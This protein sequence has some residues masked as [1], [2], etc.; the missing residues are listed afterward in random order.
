M[1]QISRAALAEL[2]GT[3]A[4]IFFGAGAILSDAFIV[5]VENFP[6]GPG[7]LAI[8]LAHGLTITVMVCA[9]GHISGG[10][11][12]PAVTLSMTLTK[13]L[14]VTH[15]LFYIVAQLLGAALAAFFL[16]AI[17]PHEALPV[18]LGTPQLATTL[19]LAQGFFTE[20]LLTFF[21]VFVIFGTAVDARGPRLL[22]GLAI[23]LTLTLGILLGGPLTG[24]ALNP[25]RAFGPA[26]AINFW[27]HH[28][29][30]WGGPMV[31]GALA[32]LLYQHL[33]IKPAQQ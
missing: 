29:I 33:F 31:G 2:L 24:G 13:R 6:V 22:A 18:K 8:A 15:S 26:L 9:L 1:I 3:F 12:N 11:F 25:A 21:L 14:S 28:W 32:A 4:L 5:Y 16:K 19:S 10:H 27:E 23:G 30:Y 7:P 20:A 17:F